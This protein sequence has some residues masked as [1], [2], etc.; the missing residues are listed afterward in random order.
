MRS[1]I[2]AAACL[3]ATGALACDDHVGECEIE[4]WVYDYTAMMEA[5]TIDGVTTCNSGKVRLRLYDGEGEGQKL[6][7][8]DTAYIEG[9]IFETIIL[10]IEEPE[11]LSIKYSIDPS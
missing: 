1:V 10:Q 11:V 4:D 8:V 6:L 3:A 9:H 7:A 5:I 2:A